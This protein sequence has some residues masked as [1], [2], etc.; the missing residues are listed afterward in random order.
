[1][2]YHWIVILALN[3]DGIVKNINIS[4]ESCSLLLTVD[5]ADCSTGEYRNMHTTF[6]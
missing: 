1:M 4:E 6:P 2:H 3:H 5:M